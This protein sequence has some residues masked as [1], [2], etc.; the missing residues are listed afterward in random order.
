M[1]IR[2]DGLHIHEREIDDDAVAAAALIRSPVESEEGS[3]I[4]QAE[5]LFFALL[6]AC[7]NIDIYR[8]PSQDGR[9]RMEWNGIER[10]RCDGRDGMVLDGRDGR[11]WKD[12]MG[13]D[14]IG[15]ERDEMRW[16]GIE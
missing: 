12:G 2:Y 16:D 14:G 15:W 10:E 8:K 4:Q 11:D 1:T 13:W 6:P 7:L 9:N 3:S 5:A